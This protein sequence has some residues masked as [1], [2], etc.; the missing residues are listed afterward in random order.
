MDAWMCGRAI[1]TNF[2]LENHEEVMKLVIRWLMSTPHGDTTLS[3][4]LATIES[5]D[6]PA[7]DEDDDAAIDDGM[8]WQVEWLSTDCELY[9]TE[10]HVAIEDA[11]VVR[12]L[13]RTSD[14]SQTTASVPRWQCH[15]HRFLQQY[16]RDYDGSCLRNSAQDLPKTEPWQEG[17]AESDRLIK[18]S[19]QC[20]ENKSTGPHST[21]TVSCADSMSV[22]SLPLIVWIIWVQCWHYW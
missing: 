10:Y 3:M 9:E 14:L 8:T 13:P 12:V 18:S 7:D 19:Q 6:E 16:Q 20:T 22:D 21:S 11:W 1:P 2:K 15:N 5:N 17:D 4:E